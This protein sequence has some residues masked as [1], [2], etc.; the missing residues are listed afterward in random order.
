ML[1]PAQ[2]N[3]PQL[4]SVLPPSASEKLWAYA[5]SEEQ[6]RALSSGSLQKPCQY[7]SSQPASQDMRDAP[8]ML[9]KI[10]VKKK[11]KAKEQ[12]FTT[13]EKEERG[14]GEEGEE[15]GKENKKV[16]VDSGRWWEKRR[17]G[18]EKEEKK[19]K[20]K[21]NRGKTERREREIILGNSDTQRPERMNRSRE[22]LKQ[23]RKGGETDQVW[24]K[25]GTET[26]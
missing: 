23:R 22:E 6:A 1:L 21:N 19:K 20:E 7:V 17:D 9:W 15:E 5:E 25:N 24:G 12:K 4:V 13:C 18:R 26:G 10:A 16:R 3:A 11:A 8:I 14:E 2:M